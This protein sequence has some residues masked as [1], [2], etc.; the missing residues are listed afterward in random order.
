VMANQASWAQIA[1]VVILK[2]RRIILIKHLK[3]IK[4]KKA[5]LIKTHF[6]YGKDKP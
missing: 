1:I 5:T 2:V 4:I 6:N 3:A